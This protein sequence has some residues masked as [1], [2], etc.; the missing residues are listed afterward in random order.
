MWSCFGNGRPRTSL[1][2]LCVSMAL[3][4]AGIGNPDHGNEIDIGLPME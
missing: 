2:C 4:H 1:T 3:R